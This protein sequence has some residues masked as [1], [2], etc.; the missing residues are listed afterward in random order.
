[1]LNHR[2]LRLNRFRLIGRI[3]NG[4]KVG[5]LNQNIIN[6]HGDINHIEDSSL[7][8]GISLNDDSTVSLYRKVRDEA[9]KLKM[10]R[11]L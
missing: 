3:Q 9:S 5:F 1:M 2:D 7:G 11:L 8:I 4:A 6:I 10:R